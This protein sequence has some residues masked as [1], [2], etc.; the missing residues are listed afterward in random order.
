MIRASSR[1][2]EDADRACSTSNPGSSSKSKTISID[3]GA[4][5]GFYEVYEGTDGNK[6]PT[7]HEDRT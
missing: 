2:E 1:V 7:C 3:E 6:C 4:E 5:V